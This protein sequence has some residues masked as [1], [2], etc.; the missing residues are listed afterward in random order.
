MARHASIP[1]HRDADGDVSAS[2]SSRQQ[3]RSLGSNEAR[4]WLQVPPV[5][6]GGWLPTM[7]AFNRRLEDHRFASDTL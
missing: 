6:S 2:T 1:R 5:H 3:L 7:R 4:G